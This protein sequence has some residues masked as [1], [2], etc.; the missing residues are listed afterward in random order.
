MASEPVVTVEANDSRCLRGFLL[1]KGAK[2]G[3]QPLWW[4]TSPTLCS[5]HTLSVPVLRELGS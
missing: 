5:P 1:G 2:C 3:A 4:S